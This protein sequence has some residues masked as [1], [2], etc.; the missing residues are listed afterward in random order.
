MAMLLFDLFGV[1]ARHQ[2]T[3]MRRR[4]EQ[5]ADVPADEFWTAYWK[6]RPPYDRGDQSGIEYWHDVGRE[7]GRGFSAERAAVLLETD[8]ESWSEIDDEMVAFLTELHRDG[9][10][11]AMLSN[12]TE[13]L[14][15]RFVANCDWLKLFELVGF[16][17]R[18][19]HAKPAPEAYLWCAR[20]L[21]V[22]VGEICFIDD[23]PENVDAA[24]ALGMRGHV[25]TSVADLRA[26]HG[27]IQQRERQV[28]TADR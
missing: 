17:C 3:A 21:G 25:F 26:A 1:I 5:L 10:R 13:E 8:L 12:I 22:E 9:V 4:L 28:G 14:A 19:G 24:L 16:S 6:L 7:L 23:R 18:I 27:R 15:A 2:A 11:L 20:Q